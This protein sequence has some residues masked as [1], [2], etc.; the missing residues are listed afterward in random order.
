MEAQNKLVLVG[1]GL[2]HIFQ[3][4]QHDLAREV[5]LLEAGELDRRLGI[6]AASRLLDEAVGAIRVLGPTSTGLQKNGTK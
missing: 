5:G 3:N 6:R 1:A 4:L 2:L